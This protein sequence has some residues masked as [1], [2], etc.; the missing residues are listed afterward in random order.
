MRGPVIARAVGTLLVLGSVYWASPGR[1]CS[2]ALPPWV[3]PDPTRVGVDVTPPVLTEVR[4]FV[5]RDVPNDCIIH[6]RVD[7]AADASDDQTPSEKLA[8]YVVGLRGDSP[9]SYYDKP[10]AYMSLSWV[11]DPMRPLDFHVRVIA[12][13][14]AGNESNPIDVHVVDGDQI[15]GGCNLVAPS[16]AATSAG[17]WLLVALAYG[18]RRRRC[19]ETVLARRR[20]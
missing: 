2:P 9:L 1:A 16:G 6:S 10:M 18:V 3:D 4:Y 12:V 14:E 15:D 11:D 7:F 17:A 5:E 13:D 19:R 8:Y 20:P